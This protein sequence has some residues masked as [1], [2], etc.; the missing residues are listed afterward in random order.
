MA[1]KKA[2][3]NSKKRGPKTSTPAKKRTVSTSSTKAKPVAKATKTPPQKEQSSVE[4]PFTRKNYML[5]LIG[6][7]LIAFG[8]ILMS[9]DDFVDA[10]EFSISLYIAPPI[11]VAGFLE[12]IYAIMYKDKTT[13]ASD[14]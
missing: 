4:L 6:V 11:V 13:P 5:L 14:T 10:S 2:K 8:F 12:I 7:G 1:A 9:M 3:S